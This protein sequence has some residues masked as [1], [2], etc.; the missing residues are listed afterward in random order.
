[1]NALRAFGAPG[2]YAAVQHGSLVTS[3]AEA[4]LPHFARTRF[5]SVRFELSKFTA[6]FFPIKRNL[7]SLSLLPV[8]RRGK[9]N[10]NVKNSLTARG[11]W[12]R[13]RLRG[14]LRHCSAAG[15]SG[16]R[17][18]G[19][20]Q[21]MAAPVASVM[22]FGRS[23][24]TRR[25]VKPVGRAAGDPG[26]RFSARRSRPRTR[27]RRGIDRGIVPEVRTRPWIQRDNR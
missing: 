22:A 15:S 9:K 5:L 12:R 8:R 17:K 20:F 27:E 2:I 23:K 10:R 4:L 18:R 14:W 13:S 1:M 19:H 11:R 16:R 26:R 24:Q 7:L 25:P 21:N 3:E 6:Y